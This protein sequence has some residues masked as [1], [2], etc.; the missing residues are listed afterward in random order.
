MRLA[1]TLKRPECLLD[2]YVQLAQETYGNVGYIKGLWEYR[3]LTP[4][5]TAVE[6]DG[7]QPTSDGFA[8]L[9]A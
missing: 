9:S 6:S 3:H 2:S 1:V 5:P 7:Q 4:E 8:E